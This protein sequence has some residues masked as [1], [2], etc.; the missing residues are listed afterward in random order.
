LSIWVQLL[1]GR[2]DAFRFAGSEDLT[3]ELLGYLCVRKT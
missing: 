3:K 1:L 2:V